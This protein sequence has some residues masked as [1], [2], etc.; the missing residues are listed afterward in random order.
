MK[1]NKLKKWISCFLVFSILQGVSVVRGAETESEPI[2]NIDNNAIAVLDFENMSDGQMGF[3]Y[4]TGIYSLGS[5]DE[6]HGNSLLLDSKE[7]GG[8]RAYIDIAEPVNSGVY[9]VTYEVLNTTATAYNYTAFNTV[10]RTEASLADHYMKTFTFQPSGKFGHFYGLDVAWTIDQNTITEYEANRWYKME[11]WIDFDRRTIDFYVDNQFFATQS[12]PDHFTAMHSLYI[13]QDK[14]SK[15]PSYWDNIGI[16]KVDSEFAYDLKAKGVN[17]PERFASY[18]N[19]SFKTDAGGHIFGDGEK[20][21]FSVSLKNISGE[22]K[23]FEAAFDVKD[24]MNNTVWSS[25]KKLEIAPEETVNEQLKINIGKK[26]GFF[27]LIVSLTDFET[28]NI[29]KGQTRFSVINYPYKE[30][31]YWGVCVHYQRVI[32]IE[33]ATEVFKN[34]GFGAVRANIGDWMDVEKTKGVYKFD[35]QRINGLSTVAKNGLGSLSLAYGRNEIYSMEHPPHSDDALTHFAN[36]AYEFT[37]KVTEIT[38]E[39][40]VY[41]E[42]WNEY[43]HTATFNPDKRPPEDYV[44]M[45]KYIYPKIKEANPKAQVV[46]FNPSGTAAEW[47]EAVFKAG[48]GEYSDIVS[49]HPYSTLSPE[50]GG[51]V[52]KVKQVK[53]LMKEYNCADKPLWAS[54]AGWSSASVGEDLQAAFAVRMMVLNTANDLIDK[55]F[56]Y[57]AQNHTVSTP[58]EQNFGLLRYW[59]N[60]EVPYEAKPVLLAISN[61]NALMTGAEFV[62]SWESGGDVNVFRYKTEDGKDALIIYSLSGSKNYAIETDADNC[63][64][65]DMYGNKSEFYAENGGFSFMVNDNPIFLIGDFGEV[66]VGK[67]PVVI[68]ETLNITGVE[69]DLSRLSVA[70]SSNGKLRYEFEMSDGIELM[71]ENEGGIDGKMLFRLGSGANDRIKIRAYNGKGLC[72]VGEIPI[73]YEDGVNVILSVVPYRNSSS[74]RWQGVLR[75]ENNSYDRPVSGTLK[76]T[77]PKEIME[78]MQKINIAEVPGRSVKSYKF[79]LPELMEES[80][81]LTAVCE[82]SNGKTYDLGGEYKLA[83]LDYAMTKPTID[84]VISDGEWNVGRIAKIDD[85]LKVT[86]DGYAG[87]QDLSGEAYLKWDDDNFYMC[88]KVTDNIQSHEHDLGRIWAGDSVQFAMAYEKLTSASRTEIGFGLDGNNEPKIDR[89][90]FM[91]TDP[92]LNFTNYEL[93]IK[94]YE[95]E[96]TTVYELAMPWSNMLPYGVKPGISRPMYL[97]MLINDNDTGTRRGWIEYG[98]GIAVEKDP[99]QFVEL[100]FLKRQRQQ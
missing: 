30:N 27:N 75:I 91:G 66:E 50:E 85:P 99:A 17:F 20:V 42:A 52:S 68:P 16:Y 49:I 71:N 36:Y 51:W 8:T 21:D 18:L 35:E 2:D 64:M 63:D 19:I 48:G 39:D 56:W 32:D 29:S 98:G 69:N 38:G 45:L 79:H 11:Q 61:Y 46:G 55:I 13:V 31:P 72:Y 26:F 47:C 78:K 10:P 60:E 82:L 25:S 57:T 95:E 81:N 12:L 67:T 4:M 83:T 44:K 53:D 90:Y 73:T 70:D 6:S 40:G 1:K 97:A 15:G 33:L 59:A 23:S 22:N 88:V 41:I 76:V 37:K 93:A 65:Y 87:P 14:Q 62:E 24:E 28:G 77:E 58:H 86:I 3:S 34:A 96:K 54:E 43:N 7:T 80:I 84:G 5:F 89:T 9:Y 92:A 74:S 94:R 100:H